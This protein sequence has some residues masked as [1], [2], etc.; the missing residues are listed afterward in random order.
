MNTE[1]SELCVNMVHGKLNSHSTYWWINLV[2]S[3]AF[4]YSMN[5]FLC[6]RSQAGESLQIVADAALCV[7][8][9]L[10]FTTHK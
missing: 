10:N 4:Q 8:L 7:T 2:I 3:D 5:G 9:M 1:Y 6:K